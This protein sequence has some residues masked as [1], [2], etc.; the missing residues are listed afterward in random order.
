MEA[1][2]YFIVAPPEFSS[3]G[4]G[5]RQVGIPQM[6]HYLQEIYL[7]SIGAARNKIKL[8]GKI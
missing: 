1:Q 8:F 4:G 2:L 3:N 6:K 7:E 5:K